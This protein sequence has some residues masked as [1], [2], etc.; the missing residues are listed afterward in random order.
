M[1][2]AAI[3]IT[4][5]TKAYGSTQALR[6]V[7]LTVQQGEIIGFLGPNG[8]GKTTAIRCMLDL[9]RPDA[10]TIRILGLDPQKDPVGVRKKIGYLPGELSL[11]S[12][13]T[14]RKL[15]GYFSSLRGKTPPWSEIEMLAERLKLDLN[16]VIRNLSKGNKQKAGIIQAVMTRPPLLLLD[17]PT[18]GL[19]P[20]MQQEVYNIL[21]EIR[22]QGTTVFFSSHII[23]EVETIAERVAIIRE[24]VIIEEAEPGRFVDMSLRR[25]QLR[26]KS[27]VDVKPLLAL[28]GVTLIRQDDSQEIVIQVKGD[29]EALIHGLA[30]LPISDLQSEHLS[31]EEAFLTYYLNGEKEEQPS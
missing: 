18:S 19:D 20:L 23:R 11:D 16:G 22:E 2:A 10:G 28:S 1:G 17:E 31:L 9:I 4:G 27:P 26:F 14:V 29:M 3:E 7:D 8:A 24:G 30:D 6:G 21:R 12:G 15:L 13:L 25:I 5:L